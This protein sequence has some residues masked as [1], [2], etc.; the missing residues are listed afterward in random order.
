MS[1]ENLNSV[2]EVDK[3]IPQGNTPIDDLSTDERSEGFDR[4]KHTDFI[5]KVAAE[6]SSSSFNFFKKKV[7]T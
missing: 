5:E 7:K 2:K 1:K 4:V 3:L 6:V